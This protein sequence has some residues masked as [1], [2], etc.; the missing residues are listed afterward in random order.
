MTVYRRESLALTTMCR[1]LNDTVQSM[2]RDN[3]ARC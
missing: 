2:I 1:K 3:E